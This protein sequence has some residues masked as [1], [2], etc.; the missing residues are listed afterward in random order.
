MG[1]RSNQVLA[2]HGADQVPGLWSAADLSFGIV[3]ASCGTL[4]KARNR[5]QPPEDTAI[6]PP[7]RVGRRTGCGVHMGTTVTATSAPP[8]TSSSNLWSLRGGHGFRGTWC[9]LWSHL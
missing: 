5:T 2:D 6:A 8:G 9:E 1:I 7:E 3:S 4:D